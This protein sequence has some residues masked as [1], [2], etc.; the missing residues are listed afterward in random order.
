MII[1]TPKPDSDKV[2]AQRVRKPKSE[3][4]ASGKRSYYVDCNVDG[5]ACMFECTLHIFQRIETQ[6]LNAHHKS[7]WELTFNE[8]GIVDAIDGKPRPY[9]AIG[10]ELIEEGTNASS[11]S[12]NP[13]VG[14]IIISRPGNK[15]VNVRHKPQGTSNAMISEIKEYL[16]K[17]YNTEVKPGDIICDKYLVTDVRNEGTNIYIQKETV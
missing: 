9:S 11:F 13:T 17:N 4:N 3:V 14:S 8:D 7:D 2:V 6:K 15:E 16:Y 12:A 1:K 10:G 5:K